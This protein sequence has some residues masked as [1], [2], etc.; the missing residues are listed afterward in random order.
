MCYRLSA[1]HIGM[2]VPG[3]SNDWMDLP[4]V[5]YLQMTATREAHLIDQI[6][7]FLHKEFS[8]PDILTSL[9][10]PLQ[11]AV[12]EEI[13]KSLLFEPLLIRTREPHLNHSE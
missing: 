5:T 13:G 11:Y 3:W 2:P 8:Y 9:R 7:H 4:L 12:P 10:V 6:R 1:M